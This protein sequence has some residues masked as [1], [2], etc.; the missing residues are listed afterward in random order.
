[1]STKNL[2]LIAT[3][4]GLLTFTSCHKDKDR[5]GP[6]SMF[7]VTIENVFE[8][9]DFFKSGTTGGLG[10]GESESITFNAGKGHYLSFA[11]MF[12]KSNDLFYAPGILFFW[13]PE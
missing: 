4:I 5:P 9:K 12:V 7:K 6:K 2:I 1:M 10:P 11:T 3:I 13:G 8:G